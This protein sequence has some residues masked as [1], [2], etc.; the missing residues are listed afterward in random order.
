MTRILT[1]LALLGLSACVQ[2]TSSST[3]RGFSPALREIAAQRVQ[4]V[5]EA[6]CLNNRS[7]A[8]QER[9]ARA[10]NL[11][12]RTTNNGLVTY[13]NPGTQ[14]YVLIGPAPDQTFNTPQGPRVFS[15]HG[16]SV[17]SPAVNQRTANRI[18]GEILSAR[19]LDG[20]ETLSRPVG[21]GTGEN[22]RGGVGFFFEDL[23]ITS[24]Q[25]RTSFTDEVTGEE[26]FFVYPAILFLHN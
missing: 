16:C 1:V 21:D 11:P 25:V 4:F 10:A 3:A 23:A 15:G 17:G 18:V 19:L 6:V 7:R 22:D 8:A 5:A 13:S 14:T 12:V 9:A 20:T 24:P 2:N 26:R